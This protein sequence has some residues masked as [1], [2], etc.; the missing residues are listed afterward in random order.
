MGFKWIQYQCANGEV[1]GREYSINGD[2]LRYER[3]FNLIVMEI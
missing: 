1:D 2:L 3:I